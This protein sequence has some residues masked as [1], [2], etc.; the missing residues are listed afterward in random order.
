MDTIATTYNVNA[1]EASN[2]ASSSASG[3]I[4]LASGNAISSTTDEL[5]KVVS[6]LQIR[7]ANLE[8]QHLQMRSSMNTLQQQ[9][10]L[11]VGISQQRQQK[12]EDS[13]GKYGKGKG[14]QNK[15]VFNHA[16]DGNDSR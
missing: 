5:K 1:A 6:S 16:P 14:T 4:D 7:V 3:R 12:G 13:K 11:L 8:E 15:E 9:L 2:D 10:G